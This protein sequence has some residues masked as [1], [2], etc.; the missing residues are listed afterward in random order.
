MQ[1]NQKNNTLTMIKSKRRG[2]MLTIGT[3]KRGNKQ[4][5]QTC[6]CKLNFV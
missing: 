2:R 3:R 4:A 6:P 5:K 1:S